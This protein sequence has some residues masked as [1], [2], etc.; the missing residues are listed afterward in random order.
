MDYCLFNNDLKHPIEFYITIDG[1]PSLSYFTTLDI[2]A[3]D[4]DRDSTGS[5]GH[6]QTDQVYIN[7]YPIGTLEGAGSQWSLTTFMVDPLMLVEGDNLV[8]I[9]VE[10]DYPNNACWCAQIDYG[11]LCGDF[12]VT[13]CGDGIRQQPNSLGVGGYYDDGY[14]DCDGGP[15]CGENC[16]YLDTWMEDEFIDDLGEANGLDTDTG[17]YGELYDSENGNFIT[18]SLGSLPLNTQAHML[19]LL[20]EDITGLIVPVDAQGFYS[21][22]VAG[23]VTSTGSF[24]PIPS[25]WAPDL[26]NARAGE[27]MREN[28]WDTASQIQD[29]ITEFGGGIMLGA[30]QSGADMG[31]FLYGGGEAI[32]YYLENGEPGLYGGTLSSAN[33]WSGDDA[34]YR[35]I[36]AATNW[37]LLAGSA[38]SSSLARGT[39]RA[40]TARSSTATEAY[41]EGNNFMR[42][43]HQTGQPE[44][45]SFQRNAPDLDRALGGQWNVGTFDRLNPR[46]TLSRVD[47]PYA[48]T[49]TRTGTVSL[50]EPALS[51]TRV[52]L[53]E[54]LHRAHP[55][56]VGHPPEFWRL[57][58]QPGL[59]EDFT[60]YLEAATG[61]T[62]K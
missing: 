33:Y 16:I 49:N 45:F 39:T 24:V 46:G 37:A 38:Y 53:E 22:G 12:D 19:A 20:G 32:S 34:E 21:G 59:K 43:S 17:I 1:D 31:M 28:R 55:Q 36:M 7:G 27:I 50:N 48:V 57:L 13:Y 44:I 42:R 40:S 3:Y 14:E 58:N 26:V 41:S 61:R 9:V 10:A 18:L 11:E 25:M 51:N 52:I 23:G 35:V 47:T 30:I 60:F 29:T 62:F 5:C 15:V 6:I 4:I 2:Y 56:I 54:Q 8:E